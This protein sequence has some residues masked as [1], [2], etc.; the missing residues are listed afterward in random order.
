[1]CGLLLSTGFIHELSV[2]NQS[3]IVFHLQEAPETSINIAFGRDLKSCISGVVRRITTRVGVG[4]T[5]IQGM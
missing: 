5:D 2:G 4:R 3:S 1:M